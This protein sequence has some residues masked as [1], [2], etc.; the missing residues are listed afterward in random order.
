[1]TMK[2]NKMALVKSLFLLVSTIFCEALLAEQQP[3]ESVRSNAF[4]GIWQ[5]PDTFERRDPHNYV[6]K[7]YLKITQEAAGRFRLIEGF[8]DGYS[9]DKGWP[10]VGDKDTIDWREDSIS[11]ELSGGKLRGSIISGNFRPTHGEKFT[12]KFTIEPTAKNKIRY[13]IWSSIR[14]GE[15]KS[16][17]ATRVGAAAPSATGVP[18]GQPGTAQ[19]GPLRNIALP[20]CGC[21]FSPAAP[22]GKK[23]SEQY[24]F[25]SDSTG[26]AYINIDGQNLVLAEVGRKQAKDEYGYCSGHRCTYSANGITAT[27]E[28]RKKTRTDYEV[29]DYDVTISVETGRIK[30]S[31]KATGSCGC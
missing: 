24:L 13:S 17:E 11:L 6:P 25:I 15:T 8:K 10:F 4:A 14:G 3:T 20:G 21:Y 16:F 7:N 31:V 9:L 19:I 30:E 28:F 22:H 1:M 2:I 12:Y 18:Q 23:A 5:Y 27:V 26:K 29:K